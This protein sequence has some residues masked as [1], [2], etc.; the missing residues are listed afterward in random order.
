M[1]NLA[2]RLH[3]LTGRVSV[4]PAALAQVLSRSAGK[5]GAAILARLQVTQG[6]RRTLGERRS[7]DV[8]PGYRRPPQNL[9][10]FDYDYYVALEARRQAQ[11]SRL[12][13]VHPSRVRAV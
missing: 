8:L 10:E 3:D 7:A 2:P 5:L 9:C 1:L 4:A 11:P 6:C 13:R 12:N